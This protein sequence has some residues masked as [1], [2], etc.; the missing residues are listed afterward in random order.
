MRIEC[1]VTFL[2]GRERYECGDIFTV[3]D[4]RGVYFTQNKWAKEV[5]A[6]APEMAATV[7]VNLSIHSAVIGTGDSN[8]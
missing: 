1:T 7:P 6:A 3:D 4:T 5:G 2:D 8:G